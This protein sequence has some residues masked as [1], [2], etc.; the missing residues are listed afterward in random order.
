MRETFT[1]PVI[2]GP[3]GEDH[4]DPFII[5]YLDAFYLYHSGETSDLAFAVRR[6]AAEHPGEP[7]ALVGFSLGGNVLL[8]T[9]A[10]HTVPENHALWATAAHTTSD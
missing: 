4:G 7:L 6:L 1:N 9:G 3:P 2:A 5:K 8:K 10:V